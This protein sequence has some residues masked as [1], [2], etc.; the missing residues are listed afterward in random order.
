MSFFTPK[1]FWWA[2]PVPEM[3]KYI[4]RFVSVTGDDHITKVVEIEKIYGNLTHKHMFEVH[5]KDKAYLISMLDFFAQMNGEPVSQQE[6]EA[7]NDTVFTVVP[8][9]SPMKTF[10]EKLWNRKKSVN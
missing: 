9:K 4:G 7:F 6:I 2:V 8:R 3:G 10:T 5:A 1:K